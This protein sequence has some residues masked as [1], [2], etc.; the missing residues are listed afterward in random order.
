VFINHLVNLTYH[1][2]ALEIAMDIGDVEGEGRAYGNIGIVHQSLGYYKL[3]L[4][5]Y[6]KRLEIALKN[7]YVDGEGRAYGNIG[8]V[9]ESITKFQFRSAEPTTTQGRREEKRVYDG[10]T[11][12]SRP[13]VF[14]TF[15]KLGMGGE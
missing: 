7:K 8:I 12:N 10:Q 2:E 6:N 1:N 11:S 9:Y 5:Y 4:E 3:A 13:T 15:Y 14:Y